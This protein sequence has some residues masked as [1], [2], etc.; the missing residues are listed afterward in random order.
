MAD[1][2][3]LPSPVLEA[4]PAYE[5]NDADA[6]RKLS[7][8]MQN[9]LSITGETEQQRLARDGDEEEEETA[10]RESIVQPNGSYAPVRPLNLRRKPQSRPVAEKEKSTW[11]NEV[12]SV[13]ASSSNGQS[14]RRALPVPGGHQQL[15]RP[16]STAQ[17]VP[18]GS[19]EGHSP[20]PPFT[21]VDNSLDGPAYERYPSNGRV[22]RS[23][24]PMVVLR[25]TSQD[26]GASPPPSPPISPVGTNMMDPMRRRRAASPGYSPNGHSQ[27]AFSSLK[28][29]PAPTPSAGFNKN[30]P[31]PPR[32]DFNPS[33]AYDDTKSV[34][35]HLPSDPVK[36]G[37]AVALYRY[38]RPFDIL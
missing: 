11:F 6:D 21:A 22:R 2:L 38:G 13:A 15:Q 3:D 16:L 31:A 24:S 28:T 4:P 12:Q 1:S 10:A 27:Q 26:I 30:I 8:A 36:R 32:L 37:E 34:Y 29:P 7:N 9:S 18:E 35:G 25:Y 14:R 33:V 17:Y 19:D 5:Y 23:A 20:P